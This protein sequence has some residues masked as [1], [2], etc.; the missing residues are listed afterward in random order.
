MLFSADSKV[1]IQDTGSVD[2]QDRHLF[3]VPSVPYKEL[4][5][6]TDGA[7]SSRDFAERNES[8]RHSKHETGL[9]EDLLKRLHEQPS[10]QTVL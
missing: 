3:G 9:D 10:Y 2:G 4:S 8:K 7:S 6:A 1:S 5:A